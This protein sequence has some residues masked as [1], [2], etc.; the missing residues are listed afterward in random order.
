MIKKNKNE[1]IENKKD[2]ISFF[3]DSPIKINKPKKSYNC[4]FEKF[5]ERKFNMSH[6]YQNNI[7]IFKNIEENEKESEVNNKILKYNKNDFSNLKNSR[8]FED[9]Q[10]F[11][12]HN[13]KLNTER[14]EK[15]EEN[16]I[17]DNFFK[18]NDIN[19]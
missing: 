16:N 15:K 10:S 5:P 18:N 19:K 7:N 8:R 9:K 6:P 1:K 3:I 12:N 17:L 13:F 14:K 4:V 11:I 2:N